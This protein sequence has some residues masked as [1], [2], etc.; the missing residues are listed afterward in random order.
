MK[1]VYLVLFVMFLSSAFVYNVEAQVLS[2][3]PR[4]EISQFEDFETLRTEF[5]SLGVERIF[6]EVVGDGTLEIM[7]D[8]QM[9]EKLNISDITRFA[10]YKL[11]S[12]YSEQSLVS[13]YYDDEIQREIDKFNVTEIFT[14]DG[15]SSDLYIYFVDDGYM[16]AFIKA[17]LKNIVHPEGNFSCHIRTGDVVSNF[18]GVESSKGFKDESLEEKKGDLWYKSDFLL[19]E[20]TPYPNPGK[21]N[22]QFLNLVGANKYQIKII[23]TATIQ[24]VIE[25]VIESWQNIDISKIP[26]GNYVI[27]VETL[28]G[29]F[30][31]TFKYVKQ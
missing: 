8:T 18:N 22:V 5:E 20:V 9:Y 10:E 6:Y 30:I 27:L 15:K 1:K 14:Q 17:H 3:E 29:D 24:T 11:V 4:K 16:Y 23:S 26:C 25:E 12:F 7:F 28:S 21:N 19:D 2:P 13:K 31:D